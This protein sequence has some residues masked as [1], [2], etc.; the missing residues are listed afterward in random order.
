MPT[1]SHKTQSQLAN[2]FAA[3]GQFLKSTVREEG[4][5]PKKKHISCFSYLNGYAE[6]DGT[7]WSLLLV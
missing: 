7:A 6:F 3:A 1:F 2:F 4:S 5:F